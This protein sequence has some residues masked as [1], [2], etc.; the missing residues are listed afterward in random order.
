M[1]WKAPDV[2]ETLGFTGVYDAAGHRADVIRLL[3]GGR[4]DLELTFLY[5][6]RNEL[7]PQ[8]SRYLRSVQEVA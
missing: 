6:S 7:T 8:L 5:L 2:T 4:T 3:Q 1:K